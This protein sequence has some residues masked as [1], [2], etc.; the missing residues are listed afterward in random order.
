[1][2][3][4]NLKLLLLSF[5][6]LIATF[7]PYGLVFEE[8]SLYV[9]KNCYLW[10][11]FSV[12]FEQYKEYVI[13]D[14][15]NAINAIFIVTM[16]V[17]IL[18]LSIVYVISDKKFLEPIIKRYAIIAIVVNLIFSYNFTDELCYKMINVGM[19]LAFL[20]DVFIVLMFTEFK[21][22]NWLVLLSTLI[23]SLPSMIIY[24][25]IDIEGGI[26]SIPCSIQMYI[27]TFIRGLVY[28]N[29][30]LWTAV[31]V[32]IMIVSVLLMTISVLGNLKC[33]NGFV[34]CSIISFVVMFVFEIVLATMEE[35]SIIPTFTYVVAI[36][37]L[38]TYLV[39]D[40][41]ESKRSI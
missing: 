18:L 39:I 13:I 37:L 29:N 41:K 34:V 35:I 2:N 20:C 26:H 19:I 4:N 40:K 33:K 6:N 3:K 8:Y 36:V 32:F 5:V 11:M 25:R 15:I 17:I 22:R 12:D 28:G 1:M 10:K 31:P 27:H 24:Y 9:E 16:A 21:K 14:V 38:V 30:P 7:L 23:I